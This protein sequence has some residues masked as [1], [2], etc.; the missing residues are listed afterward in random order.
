VVTERLKVGIIAAEHSSDRL[1]AKIIKS[2]RD[3]FEID[4]FG[5]GG[6]EVN[7]NQIVTPSGIDYHDLHVMG[8]IDP[9]IKLPKIFLNRRKLLKL[10]ISSDIDIFIGVDSPDF[11]IFFHKKLKSHNVKTIQV[12]SPSVWGWRENRIKTIDTY[13]DLTMCLFKFECDFY[14]KKNMQSFFL[15]H[16]FSQLKPKNIEDIIEYHSLEA[17]KNFI[18]ILPGSRESEIFELM[19][20][21]IAAAK[22]LLNQDPNAY[23]LIPAANK[24]LAMIIESTKGINE[25]P[26]K[27]SLNSAQDFLTLS[28]I[29]IVTSGTA[30]LE[31]AVLGSSPIIC[32]KTNKINYAVLS[33]MISTPFVGLPNL[34]L[35][36][37]I[38]PELIQ[39][40]L[41]PD[42]IVNSYLK[43]FSNPD[44]YQSYVSEINDAMSGKGFDIAARTIKNLL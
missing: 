37:P 27:L 35:Q 8:L 26:Y 30:T 9:L 19:P 15:G 14:S 36:K 42:S 41:T 44:Q 13:I 38:F 10:F 39:N 18:S 24:K 4:L 23:F 33:R 2:L 25:I 22:K 7:A 29:S 28:P 17:S 16:P 40:D 6:P 3:I 32:Y 21:Y 12:V 31:A 1:G 5:L 34:L 43:I 11:N 20:V